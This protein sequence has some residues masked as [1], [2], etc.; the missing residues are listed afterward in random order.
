MAALEREKQLKK[1]RRSKKDT[2]T[3]SMN[4]RWQDLSREWYD[5]AR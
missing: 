2:L 4:P 1:W 3:E 5:Q